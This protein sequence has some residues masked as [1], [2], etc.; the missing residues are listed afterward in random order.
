M[1]LRIISQVLPR[2]V[3]NKQSVVFG[4]LGLA[5]AACVDTS[6]PG[7]LTPQGFCEEQASVQCL[8]YY[9]CL[10]EADR[11]TKRPDLLA[12]GLDIGTSQSTCAQNLKGLCVT[13]PFKCKTGTTFQEMKASVCADSLSGVSCQD[14][15]DGKGDPIVCDKVCTPTVSGN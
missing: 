10:T 6:V 1:Y 11:Q 7:T 15:Q 12:A 13:K 3:G 9:S 14:W 5:L 4:V 8:R 2:F